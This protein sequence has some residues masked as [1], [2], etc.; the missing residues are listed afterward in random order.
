MVLMSTASPTM[1]ANATRRQAMIDSQLRPSD[2]IDP[3]LLRAIATVDRADFVP[4]ERAAA[5]YADRAV[6]LGGGRALNAP[7][8]TARLIADL[9][10][11]PGAR[12]LLIGAA[13]GY[14]AAVLLALGVE[15]VAVEED[16]GLAAHMRQAL[17]AVTL[18]E[19]PLGAGAPAHAPYDALLID[20]AVAAIP[21][22]LLAQLAD[23]ARIAAG[24]IDGPVTRLARGV[25]VAGA[26]STGLLPFADSDSVIL[27]GFAASRGFTF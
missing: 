1:S 8:A 18:V 21:A 20:G 22:S 10:P 17:P 19:G 14:A 25:Q 3:R 12:V 5:A 16:A 24:I 27:P 7:L 6:P 15:V 4:A 13:T 2:V 9:D 26:D 23:G 11:V